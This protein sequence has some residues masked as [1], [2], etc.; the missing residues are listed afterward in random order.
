M[1]EFNKS[2]LINL[3]E[4]IHIYNSVNNI[5]INLDKNKSYLSRIFTISNAFL[6]I[7]F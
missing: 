7:F 4:E 2:F 6:I 1:A 5:D 3:P